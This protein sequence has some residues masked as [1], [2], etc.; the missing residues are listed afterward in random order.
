MYS[1]SSAP[2]G[3]TSYI[4]SQYGL[5]FGIYCAYFV[6]L[7]LIALLIDRCACFDKTVDRLGHS[8]H[9]AFL[10]YERPKIME[11]EG[12]KDAPTDNKGC[13]KKAQ[14]AKV[15]PSDVP[16]EKKPESKGC[17][18]RLCSLLFF[19]CVTCHYC[20]CGGSFVGEEYNPLFLLKLLSA[21]S[22]F[23]IADGLVC[24]CCCATSMMGDFFFY[25]FNHHTILSMLFA[26]KQNV[27]SRGERR[28]AFYVQNCLAF[29]FSI[30]VVSYTTSALQKAVINVLVITPISLLVNTS[31]YYLLACPCLIR[32]W[33]W[34]CSQWCASWCEKFGKVIAYPFTLVAVGLLLAAAAL[35]QSDGGTA[36][37]KYAYQ[38][39]VTSIFVDLIM[40]TFKFRR[41]RF[42]SFKF[43]SIPVFEIGNWFKEQ[44]AIF[45]LKPDENFAITKGFLIP[46]IITFEHWRRLP[47]KQNE[48]PLVLDGDIEMGIIAS[49][50]SIRSVAVAPAPI[51]VDQ[52]PVPATQAI[53]FVA[54][55]TG[56]VPGETNIAPLVTAG[57]LIVATSSSEQ[58]VAIS[59]PSPVVVNAPIDE[60]IRNASE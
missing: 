37:S 6:G 38:V 51:P 20:V 52:A 42:T 22:Y 39:H 4:E 28:I 11:K 59:D 1:T 34:A 9:I 15:A 10:K 55:S 43:C 12:K 33:D 56:Y 17:C 24:C 50:G 23:G 14:Y 3:S 49:P 7:V 19:P 32:E 44:V 27:F 2:S 45:E 58:A 41:N 57:P 36:V 16:I 40:A 53:A 47:G 29:F 21:D 54:P 18:S 60:A 25:L 26:S 13:C 30:L 35:S 5:T 48:R 8:A 31:Y 46:G